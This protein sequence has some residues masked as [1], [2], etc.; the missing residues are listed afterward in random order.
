[1]AKST[2]T[3]KPSNREPTSLAI[4]TPIRTRDPP[5]SP[6]QLQVIDPRI[7]DIDVRQRQPSIQA[8]PPI[9]NTTEQPKL[10]SIELAQPNDLPDTQSQAVS[11]SRSPSY[12]PF[13]E[14]L[15][16]EP[17][18]KDSQQQKEELDDKGKVFAWTIELEALLFN[19]L[20]RQVVDLGKR[21]NSRFKNEAWKEVV[22][23]IYNETG[24]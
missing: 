19:E 18:I 7:L 22:A 1:M 20:V 16:Q 3:R 9:F 14:D 12:N 4:T 23:Y 11:W 15:Q 5:S 13:I 2:R 17:S 24:Y 6:D 21:A 10:D 8:Q